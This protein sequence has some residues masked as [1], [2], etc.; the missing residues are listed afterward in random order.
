MVP[1]FAVIVPA[2]AMELPIE[3]MPVGI[4]TAPASMMKL[5]LDVALVS[6]NDQPPADELKTILYRF[7][8]LIRTVF[9]VVVALKS[10]VP[11]LCWTV[12]PELLNEPVT[13]VVPVGRVTV[14]ALIVKLPVDVANPPENAQLP[15]EPLK[16]R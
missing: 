8:P 16:V 5:L 4:V 1:L 10:M 14:P 3:N 2:F 6:E 15:P 13:V 11:L 12:P 7:E 9:P